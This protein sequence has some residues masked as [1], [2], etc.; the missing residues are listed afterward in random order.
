MQYCISLNKNKHAWSDILKYIK[1]FGFDDIEI[2]KAVDGSA[3]DYE[4]KHMLTPWTY[5]MITQKIP[6]KYHSQLPS[7]GAIGCYLSHVSI[8]QE[9]VNSREEYAIIFED[10]I[11]FTKTFNSEQIELPPDFDIYFLGV[12]WEE[13]KTQSELTYRKINS[14]FFGTHGYIITRQCAMKLLQFAF[15]I[16]IQIDAFIYVMMMRLNLAIYVSNNNICS[17]KHHQS[18]IQTMCLMCYPYSGNNIIMY[19]F[20]MLITVVCFIWLLKLKE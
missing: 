7:K 11:V 17:Q 2:F 18:N 15:P 3:L 9:L 16:E 10:D 12:S 8:W 6:R 1:S 19:F 4:M 13:S 5:Y 14:Q 20:L